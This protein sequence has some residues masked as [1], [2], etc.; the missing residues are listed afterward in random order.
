MD[1]LALAA[2]LVC[3][4]VL[5]YSFYRMGVENWNA[6]IWIVVTSLVIFQVV[7]LVV[8]IDL[9]VSPPSAR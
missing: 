1:I 2:I 3:S 8:I 7:I 5:G 4:V 6:R 9:L